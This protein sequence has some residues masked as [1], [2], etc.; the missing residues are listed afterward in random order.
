MVPHECLDF[1]GQ[2]SVAV[3]SQVIDIRKGTVC[4]PRLEATDAYGGK[5]IVKTDL[6][7]G[8]VP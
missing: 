6:N 5:V 2:Y 3:N 8:G 1:A 4:G 7:H